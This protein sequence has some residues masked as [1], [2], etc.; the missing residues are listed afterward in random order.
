MSISGDATR[1]L[2]PYVWLEGIRRTE[3]LGIPL[4]S[5]S[6]QYGVGL[7]EGIMAY[8]REG[9]V[10]VIA[11][12]EHLTRLFVSA[13]QAPYRFRD[14]PKLE[15]AA[16]QIVAILRTNKVREQVYIRPTLFHEGTGDVRLGP[17]LEGRTRFG[18]YLQ[19]WNASYLPG[20][21][22][23]HCTVSPYEKSWSPTAQMKTCGNYAAAIEAKVEARDRQNALGEPFDE[24]LLF[25]RTPRGRFLAEGSSENVIIEWMGRLIEP[26][27]DHAPILPGIT[28][29]IAAKLV[30][31]AEPGRTIE[32]MEITEM[33]ATEDASGMVLTG[34]AAEI[35]PVAAV[36][37]FFYSRDREPTPILAA[38]VDGYRRFTAGAYPRS[39]LYTDV[40]T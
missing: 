16:E 31:E 25:Y 5:P 13:R 18:V 14:L 33:I 12:K 2:Y 39:D 22:G 32:Q 4:S 27:L 6:V 37:G 34:T 40:D 23:M 7:F 19:R 24:T 36:D 28:R 1:A 30:E 11:L 3:D 8:P 17:A 35:V 10:R 20:G 38:L 15:Q 29:Q 21:R 9:G 26:K